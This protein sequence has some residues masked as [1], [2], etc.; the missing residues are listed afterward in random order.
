MEFY[1]FS[2]DF[3]RGSSFGKRNHKHGLT[4]RIR[5]LPTIAVFIK[6][7]DSEEKH[8]IKLN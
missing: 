5:S 8:G 2:N 7:K 6:I 3:R 4:S 1:S